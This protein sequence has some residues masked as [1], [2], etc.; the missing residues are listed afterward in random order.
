MTEDSVSHWFD[1]PMPRFAN[2]KAYGRTVG[3]LLVAAASSA[4]IAV[5]HRSLETS[6]QSNAPILPARPANAGASAATDP[7]L[8]LVIRNE[9]PGAQPI[10]SCP[11]A[12]ASQWD[13]GI[14][15]TTQLVTSGAHTYENPWTSPVH[16]SGDEAFPQRR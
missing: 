16:W 8:F 15:A 12:S 1:R 2:R 3:F 10:F 6:S 4:L 13:F 11:A 14:N 7:T 9:I 5:T